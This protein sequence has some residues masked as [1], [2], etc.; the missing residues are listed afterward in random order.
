MENLIQDLRFGFR[1]LKSSPV[2]S[3]VAILALALGIGAN[4]MIFSVVNALLLKPLPF[5]KSEQLTSVMVRDPET[6]ALYGAYSYP[7]FA[8]VRDRNHVFEKV[9][10]YNGSTSF[11]QSGDEP[12]K[13][14]GAA[15]SWNLFELL[16]VKPALGRTFTSDEEKE[17][18]PFIVLGYNLW[19][20]RFGADPAIIGKQLPMDGKQVTVLG[21]MPPGFKFPIVGHDVDYWR[22][23]AASIPKGALTAR[24][25]VF[26]G[27]VARLRDGV[28]LG[29]AQAE[30]S[31]LSTALS[32]EY[33]NEDPGMN[34][35]VIASQD[36]LVRRIRP[37]LLVLLGA[38]GFVLLIACA[39]VANLLL[40]RATV[41][42]REIA[43]RSA[44][45]ASRWRVIRQLLTESLLLS[46]LGAVAG[47]LLALWG[48]DVLVAASPADI[49]RFGQI[50]LDANVL[51]FTAILATV[52]GI[53][54]GL[55]P[56]VTASGADINETLKDATRGMTGGLHRNRIRSAMVVSEIALSLILLVGAGLLIQSFRRLMNVSPGFNSDGVLTAALAVEPT[57]YPENKS[58]IEVFHQ[59]LERVKATP[60]VAAAGVVYPLPLGG[61]AEVF[62]FDIGGR[63][64]YQ[65]GEEPIADR[66]CISGDYFRAM[67]I[68]IRSGRTFE[69]ADRAESQQV[70]I[71]NETLARRYFSGLNPIGQHLIPGEGSVPIDR[72]IVGVVGD[73]R[74]QSLESETS[75]EY[76]VPYTQTEVDDLTLVLRT[77]GGNPAAIAPTLHD[78]IR[79][80][81]RGIP[82][83]NVKTMNQLLSESN[84]RRGFNTVLLAGFALLALVLAGIGIYGVMSYS[85]IQRTREI[86]IRMALGAQS[87]D[88]LSLIIRQGV[89]LAVVGL[90]VGLTS[91]LFITRVMS[92]LVFG[93]STTDPMTYVF[94]ALL[95]F[96]IV[97]AA[98]Y[99]PARR[100][101]RTDPTEALRCE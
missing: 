84:A 41:R 62:T 80:I 61:S 17:G 71:I 68:P 82:F 92:S 19:Q 37:A 48:I 93:V 94:V 57:R 32:A 66:R 9:S 86:G 95:L 49:P 100:A 3:L 24:G 88:V 63:P 26:L 35:A 65:P 5:A 52:T 21:I 90:A 14:Q 4:T 31:T 70:V 60:G 23:L 11:L 67:G 1:M 101:A 29:Q 16:K 47:L 18:G 85:V 74:H 36:L 10:A 59:T 73:V 83:Y 75:P 96:V 40:A 55:A 44:M 97:V 53:L 28:S 6:G 98:C 13:I 25:A 20:A 58:R 99:L 81:D 45:G 43:I 22:P 46:M 77:A 7:N 91:S 89:V 39:N 38:V 56:A 33:P 50:G 79:A 34:I 54:F 78:D 2:F 87:K 72:E 42:K 15:V 51:G 76:Y 64:P 8:D 27:V 12:E 30:M 69:D